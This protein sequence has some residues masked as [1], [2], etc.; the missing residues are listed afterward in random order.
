[1]ETAFQIFSHLTVVGIMAFG[2]AVFNWLITILLAVVTIPLRD[3]PEHARIPIIIKNAL[4]M[5]IL[6][7]LM[8]LATVRF[9]AEEPGILRTLTGVV[10]GIL[11]IVAIV[12]S[13]MYQRQ[14]DADAAGYDDRMNLRPLEPMMM[15]LALV[16]FVAGVFIPPIAMPALLTPILTSSY[17]IVGL[18]VIS[19][20]ATLAGAGLSFLVVI[21]GIGWIIMF[22]GMIRNG[23]GA[24]LG[25]V[26][27]E[28]EIN[29]WLA[30]GATVGLSNGSNW[31]LPPRRIDSFV[32]DRNRQ[33][34]RF[35]W[36]GENITHALTCDKFT[37]L[38]DR[39]CAY[40]SS[41][42]DVYLVLGLGPAQ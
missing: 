14:K 1:M 29:K 41:E 11:A 4:T 38:G 18:P 23:P 42:K 25:M 9:I 13:D 31:T 17:W 35:K 27:S 7:S 39:G 3:R 28:S 26:P 6:G 30:A 24:T 22:M 33:Q 5:Y 40:I 12:G 32:F 15:L 34:V 2:F 19:W 8:V 16:V 20:L 21:F 36:E 10:L 37:R